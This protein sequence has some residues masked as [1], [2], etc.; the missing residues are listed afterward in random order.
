MLYNNT[1]NNKK[2]KKSVISHKKNKLDES[3][4]SL[5]KLKTERTSKFFDLNLQMRKILK[6]QKS[7]ISQFYKSKD[8]QK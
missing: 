8:S 6:K 2:E 4:N 1:K 3:I 7:N 5:L